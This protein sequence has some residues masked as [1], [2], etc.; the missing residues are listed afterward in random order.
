MEIN[1]RLDILLPVAATLIAL[2]L[3]DVVTWSWWV[4]LAPLWVT[5]AVILLAAV[6][7]AAAI[8]LDD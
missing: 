6:V 7:V 3:L 8:W 2:R 5:G 4:I 1:I